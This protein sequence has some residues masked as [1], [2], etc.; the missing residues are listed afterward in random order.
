MQAVHPMTISPGIGAQLLE[1]DPRAA[2]VLKELINAHGEEE[3]KKLWTLYR[4][5]ISEHT[6]KVIV[7]LKEGEDEEGEGGLSH[8]FTLTLEL[9]ELGLEANFSAVT[10]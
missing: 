9:M 5:K 7:E 4:K 8:L 10:I 2:K 3:G 6:L 1:V